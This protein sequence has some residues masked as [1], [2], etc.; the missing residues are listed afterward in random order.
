MLPRAPCTNHIQPC[1]GCERSRDSVSQPHAVRVSMFDAVGK[2]TLAR[3]QLVLTGSATEHYFAARFVG[4]A[5]QQGV[6]QSRR[7]RSD[8]SLAQEP[9]SRELSGGWFAIRVPGRTCSSSRFRATCFVE[10]F[11]IG[12]ALVAARSTGLRY[13]AGTR[14]APTSKAC[15]KCRTTDTLRQSTV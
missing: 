9:A 1:S 12:A 5:L 8:S 2:L 11:D 10:C 15:A 4:A 14:P 13:R 7:G 6:S 3:H